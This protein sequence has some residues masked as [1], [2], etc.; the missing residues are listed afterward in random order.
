[1]EIDGKVI[2]FLTDAAERA[3]EVDEKRAAEAIK[4][5]QSIMAEKRHGEEG[6]ADAVAQLE[7][8][9]SRIKIAKKH[10]R[11]GGGMPSMDN[12]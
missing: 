3:Q 2:T 5:A 11:R 6:Y 8:A 10:N 9:L 7:R 4:R 12:N 1:M